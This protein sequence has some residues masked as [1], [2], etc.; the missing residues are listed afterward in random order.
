MESKTL[1]KCTWDHDLYRIMVPVYSIYYKK[2]SWRTVYQG[3]HA[4]CKKRF[5][6]YPDHAEYTPAEDAITLKNIKAEYIF[7]HNTPGVKKGNI[8]RFLESLNTKY[9]NFIDAEV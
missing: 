6:L 2:P 4:E 1:I 7:L 5:D 8:D 9:I 3:P